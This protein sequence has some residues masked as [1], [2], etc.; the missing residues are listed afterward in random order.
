MYFD[1]KCEVVRI[2]INQIVANYNAQIYII[3]SVS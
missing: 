1:F 2:K 3:T